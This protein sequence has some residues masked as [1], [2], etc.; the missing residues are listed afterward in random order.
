MQ[1]LAS[2]GRLVQDGDAH[3][4]KMEGGVRTAAS[5]RAVVEAGIPVMGHVG[6]TPQS[7]RQFGGF[8]VRRDGDRVLTDAKAVTA[9]V[10]GAHQANI[11]AALLSCHFRLPV[12]RAPGSASGSEMGGDHRRLL[13]AIT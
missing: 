11:A 5:I 4:F 1:A 10:G 3:A 9:A 8:R 12:D 13:M 6:L 2:A 7:V